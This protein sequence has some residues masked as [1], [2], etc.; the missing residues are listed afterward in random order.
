[1]TYKNLETELNG[2]V[3]TIWLNRPEVRNAIDEH[4]IAEISKVFSELAKN[5]RIRVLVLAGRGT[6]FCAGGDIDWMRRM[7]DFSPEQNL[8]DARML[9]QML[10]TVHTSPKPVI[11]RVHGPAYA[12]GMGLAAAGDIVVADQAAEFCLSEVRIGLVP[13]TIS[14]YVIRALGIRA[15]QRYMLT[16]ERLSAQEAFRLGFVHQLSNVG[17]IDEA[18]SCVANALIAAGPQALTKTKSL[19]EDV[20]LRGPHEDVMQDTAE[21]IANVRASSEGR[22]GVTAFLA[23]RKPMWLASGGAR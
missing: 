13:A 21:R 16:G 6:S 19:I 11:A 7:A 22:E 18:V 5:E 9:A 15:S 23:K 14:P 12:G 1:M 10:K 8:R 17:A 3:A 20:G 2:A 4:L